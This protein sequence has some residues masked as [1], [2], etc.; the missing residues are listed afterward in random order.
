MIWKCKIITE[1]E[2]PS[3]RCNAVAPCFIAPG[4]PKSYVVNAYYL[5]HLILTLKQ[6]TSRPT[7][8]SSVRANHDQKIAPIWCHSHDTETDIPLSS[9]L[10]EDDGILGRGWMMGVLVSQLD[11]HMTAVDQPAQILE[12]TTHV[13]GNPVGTK[14]EVRAREHGIFHYLAV[15]KPAKS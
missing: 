6:P 2:P 9:S 14:M 10:F 11:F 13:R 5:R 1:K 15:Q 3:A 8:S 4:N 7:P 12:A